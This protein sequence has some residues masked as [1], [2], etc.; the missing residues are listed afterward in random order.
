[1]VESSNKKIAKNTL[2]LYIR[3]AVTMVIALYASRVVLQQLGVSDYGI[4]NVVGGVIAMLTTLSG[5]LSGATQRFITVAIGRKDKDYLQSVFTAAFKV[6][7]YLAIIVFIIAETIGLWYVN[8]KMNLPDG[9]LGAANFVFQTVAISFLVDIL[10]LPYNGAMRAYER[11]GAY[12][13]ISIF[14]SVF[15][16]LLILTLSLW[17]ND[18]LIVYGICELVVSL[19][20]KSAYVIYGKVHFKDLKFVKSKEKRVYKEIVG[21][22]GWNFLGT[23]SSVIYTQGSNLVLNFFYGVLWNAAMG[24][25]QQ[26]QNAI[27]SFVADFTMAVNPQIYKTYASGDW[28]RTRNLMF[29]GVKIASFLMLIIGGPIVVNVQYILNLWLVDVPDHTELFVTM[30]ILASFLGVVVNPFN[31]LMQAA[32]KLKNYQI[33]CFIINTS[34]VIIL[35]FFF[36]TGVNPVA[37]FIITIIQNII[38]WLLLANFSKKEI[39]FPVMKFINMILLK[40]V[41]YIIPIIGLLTFKYFNPYLITF[42]IFLLESTSIVLILS[43][44]FCFWGI[45]RNE[46]QQIT[47]VVKSRLKKKEA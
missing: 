47:V 39:N 23:A 31:T 2:F 5:T 36:K 35:Y 21:F 8:S 42:P 34:S 4:Y 25:T 26:V 40:N 30:S 43:L 18:K 10:T 19:S 7:L 12:A 14:Q 44:M 32:G 28:G 45:D 37:I 38:K 6:H 3:T 13:Y 24:V 20:A 11:F 15:R 9:R 16:L 17:P 46:R 27:S 1:M 33:A 22:T 29:F 41:C